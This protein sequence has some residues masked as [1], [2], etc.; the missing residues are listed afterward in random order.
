MRKQQV[1]VGCLATFDRQEV[2]KLEFHCDAQ[3]CINE[4]QGDKCTGNYQP[5]CSVV[6]S[7]RVEC[8]GGF[9]R[10][11]SRSFALLEMQVPI[12]MPLSIGFEWLA[13]AI[14]LPIASQAPVNGVTIC[15]SF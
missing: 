4:S 7:I 8:L 1:E 13:I 10:R 11:L 12:V 3:L 9:G 5:S 2:G 15:R 14:R 6:G